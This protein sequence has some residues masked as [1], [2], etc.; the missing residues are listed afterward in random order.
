[1]SFDQLKNFV[2]SQRLSGVADERITELLREKHWNEEL[3]TQALAESASAPKPTPSEL[4]LSS[5]FLSVK[6]LLI[7]SWNTLKANFSSYVITAIATMIA[8]LIVF[9]IFL[10]PIVYD[11]TV[12][13]FTSGDFLSKSLLPIVILHSLLGLITLILVSLWGSLALLTVVAHEGQITLAHAYKRA[14]E[15]LPGFALI[16]LLSALIT[17]LGLIVFII[18]GIIFSLYLT[19]ASLAYVVHGARGKS[20]L[21]SS[22]TL[23]HGRWWKTLWR[24]FVPSVIGAFIIGMAGSILPGTGS[25]VA[26]IIVTPFTIIYSFILYQNY[27]AYNKAHPKEESIDMKDISQEVTSDQN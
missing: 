15:R 5:R 17:L 8:P 2:S 20:A 25:F 9:V 16:S 6:E 13:H 1:M 11:I 21:L 19:F 23:V 18:P 7:A 10:A 24:I 3:I 26:Q 14:W 22:V 4:E 12:L 27:M